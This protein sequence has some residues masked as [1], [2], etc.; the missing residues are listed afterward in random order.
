VKVFYLGSHISGWLATAGVPLFVSHRRL[1]GKSLPRAAAGWAVD[2]GAYT[3]LLLF[4]QWTTTAR[5]YVQAVRRY[6]DEIGRL[7]WAAPQD[8]TC[9]VE[10]LRRTGMSLRQHQRRTIDNFIELQTLWGDPHTSP[11]MPV[12]QG[13]STSNYVRCMHMYARAGIDLTHFPS[14][15]RIGVPAPGQRGGRRHRLSDARPRPRHAHAR[16]R[17][18]DRRPG[19]LRAQGTHRRQPR[20]ELPGHKEPTLPGHRHK[21]CASCL[22]Y[23]LQWRQHVLAAAPSWQLAGLREAP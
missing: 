23:A 13:F 18:Q 6:D 22:D 14:R 20:V 5:Q 2:S 19:P 3:E 4:G 7:E 16:L 15:Y 21:S 9:E 12:L 1:A 8:L 17:H 11:F 10:V